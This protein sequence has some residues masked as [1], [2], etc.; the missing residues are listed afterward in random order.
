[1]NAE[2]DEGYAVT[3]KRGFERIL[4]VC[5]VLIGA[6]YLS[7]FLPFRQW[8]RG[9][10]LGDAQLNLW[11]LSWQWRNL[12]THPLHLWDANAF[13]PFR[14]T[15]CGS[16]HLFSEVLLGEPFFLLTHNPFLAYHVTIL[17]ALLIGAFGL[18]RLAFYY[19]RSFPAALIAALYYSIALPRL[20]HAPSHIQILSS[21]W[22]PWSLLYLHLF[23]DSGK[24][25]DAAIFTLTFTLQILSGWYLAVCE[26]ILISVMIFGLY[27]VHFNLRRLA[28]IIVCCLIAVLFVIPFAIP[29]MHHPSISSAE[30]QAYSARWFDYF[31]PFS[32][33][34]YAKML[35]IANPVSERSVFPGY[36]ILLLVAGLL[37]HPDRRKLFVRKSI[38]GLVIVFA[39][40]LIFSLGS[41]LSYP[42]GMKLPFYY[43]AKYFS[44]FNQIRAPARFSQLVIFVVSILAALGFSGL[45]KRCCTVESR[46]VL[47]VFI[48]LLICIEQ[49]PFLRIEPSDQSL[50][51]VYK[52]VKKQPESVVIAEF[53]IYFESDLW[54]FSAE[55]M[56]S[57]ALHERRIVNG[58]TRFVPA[59][60]SEQMHVLK[61][62]P[63]PAAIRKLRELKVDYI[64]VHPHKYFE[65]E[66][67]KILSRMSQGDVVEELNRVVRM[68]RNN[69]RSIHSLSGEKIL[70]DA[71]RS[72]ELELVKRFPRDVVF[73]LKDR[74]LK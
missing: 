4:V 18:F 5:S 69:Y 26:S 35:H 37:F 13:Y 1:M 52:W 47:T 15:I 57:A 65:S 6:I 67:K 10:L 53:P 71:L 63:A 17:L 11:A 29:Y 55:Y 3:A 70:S 56:V 45:Y 59:G 27:I 7:Y 14:Q 64:L 19:S 30:V 41:R 36:I 24:K 72:P 42:D 21:H 50:L 48:L 68:E 49:Y 66:M 51:P 25:T 46:R 22:M 12:L 74:P 62:F 33:T 32:N 16:D 34:L 54:A 9:V 44:V 2:T 23:R 58:Y 60:F 8:T 39:V 40:A 20:L 28:G 31:M 61:T 73:R 43:L 38:S